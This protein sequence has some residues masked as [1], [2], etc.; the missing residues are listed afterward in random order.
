MNRRS[1][2]KAL[3]GGAVALSAGGIALL[4]AEPIQR[5]YFLPPAG[6]WNRGSWDLVLAVEA[7]RIV[8]ER[9]GMRAPQF[10]Y[11]LEVCESFIVESRWTPHVINL[12]ERRRHLVERVAKLTRGWQPPQT[13]RNTVHGRVRVSGGT[14]AQVAAGQPLR[15][16]RRS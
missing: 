9:L 5:T 2:L 3:A 4:E 15:V 14:S 12:I 16:L 6:G 11:G 8:D 13:F 7:L 10:K 1:F